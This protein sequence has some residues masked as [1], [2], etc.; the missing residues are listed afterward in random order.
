[1]TERE[2]I[3][4]TL[5]NMH[6]LCQHW[7]ETLSIIEERMK[8]AHFAMKGE[9][10]ARVE[11]SGSFDKP[12]AWVPRSLARFYRRADDSTKGVGVCLHF[13]PYSPSQVEALDQLKVTLP[14]A[15]VSLVE[16][17]TAAA[18]KGQRKLHKMLSEAGWWNVTGQRIVR[19]VLVES[20]VKTIPGQALTYFVDLF[21]LRT[22]AGIAQLVVDPMV[23]MYD[24]EREHVAEAR[25]Q[26]FRL[27][28]EEAVAEDRTGE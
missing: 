11:P 3:E 10:Y 28:E 4:R 16:V 15:S 14:A 19:D 13:G 22:L 12:E 18:F 26:V 20:N 17:T 9:T 7:A 8:N 2:K 21:S 1:M 23:K 5:R 24:G 27:R 25:L 6:R